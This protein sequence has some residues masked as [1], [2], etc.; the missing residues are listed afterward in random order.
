[1]RLNPVEFEKDDDANFHMNFI[2]AASNL[3][4]ANYGIQPADR[5]KTKF[6]DGK[7][8]PVIATTT[9]LHHETEWSLWDTYIIHG[10]FQKKKP[11]IRSYNVILWE[12]REERKNMKLSQ[13]VENIS[14]KPIPPH[15]KAL[16]LEMCVN[17][18]NITIF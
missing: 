15:V 4:D 9:S 6:I 10:L 17:D 13:L 5:H 11:R 2:T 1:Y 12:K 18:R 3:R 8:I 16:T 14:K 7:I